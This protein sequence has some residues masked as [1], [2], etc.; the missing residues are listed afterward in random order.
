M[1]TF[2]YPAREEIERNMPVG[3][4]ADAS[5]TNINGVGIV[6]IK[7]DGLTEA[8]PR[9]VVGKRCRNPYGERRK[10]SC[11]CDRNRNREFSLRY[12]DHPRRVKLED[13]SRAMLWQPYGSVTLDDAFLDLVRE[14]SADG[15]EVTI[16]PRSDHV[17]GSTVGIIF[18][19][20]R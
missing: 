11:Y 19:P 4:P 15:I 13:G 14:C 3:N 1:P 8:C 10:A 20:K 2:D 5:I 12:I 9:W 16:S 7:M 6:S 18:T 17:P